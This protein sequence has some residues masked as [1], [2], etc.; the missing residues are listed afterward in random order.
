[1][2]NMWKYSFSTFYIF[3]RVETLRYKEE[4]PNGILRTVVFDNVLSFLPARKVMQEQIEE[5]NEIE[6]RG[7]AYPNIVIIH[8]LWIEF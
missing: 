8:I 5:A 6:Y 2:G 4:M 7:A 3:P 1:M